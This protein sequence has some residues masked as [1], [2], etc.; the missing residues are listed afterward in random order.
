MYV[1]NSYIFLSVPVFVCSDTCVWILWIHWIHE[2]IC[3]MNSNICVKSY[4]SMNLIMNG[5]I[6]WILL[7]LEYYKW[8]HLIYEFIYVINSYIL[9]SVRVFVCSDTCVW[10]LWIH[11]IHEWICYTNSFICVKWYVS[12]NLNANGC[13]GWIR[14]HWV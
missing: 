3:Y 2:L 13:I 9:L 14:L 11:W 1:M 6:R 7:Y 5:Y 8:L 4:V 10:I 12:M